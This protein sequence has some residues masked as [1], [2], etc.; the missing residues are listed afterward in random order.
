MQPLK[1]NPRMQGYTGLEHDVLQQLQD[2]YRFHDSRAA[3][4]RVVF[5]TLG[6]ACLRV[7]IEA[8]GAE[9][10][11]VDYGYD[12]AEYGYGTRAELRADIVAIL[13]DEGLAYRGHTE[14]L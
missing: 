8:S 11:F 1:A 4:P 7:T 6:G 10:K 9:S 14:K 12:P 13:G 3:N 5:N 2:F